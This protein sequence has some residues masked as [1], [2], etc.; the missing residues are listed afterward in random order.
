MYTL[1]QD[2][3]DFCVKIGK[4]RSRV[5]KRENKKNMNYSGRDD[6]E[7]NIQG[8]FGE[9][10]LIKLFDDD[11]KKLEDT[12]CRNT[13]NDTFDVH[14]NIWKDQDKNDCCEETKQKK[15]S[16]DVK[17]TLFFDAPLLI[18]TWKRQNPPDLFALC[19]WNE[20]ER[21]V[22]LKGFAV[23]KTQLIM[24]NLVIK[25]SRFRNKFYFCIPQNQLHSFQEA[26]QIYSSLN[27][28]I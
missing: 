15:L 5:N 28:E 20:D 4:E 11:V 27:K 3:Y 25:R 17:T 6:E 16:V 21:T 14:I 10:A 23:S 12:T 13:L 2:E 7:I 26:C 22:C 1:S 18:T 19:I 9:Y 24:D 8:V